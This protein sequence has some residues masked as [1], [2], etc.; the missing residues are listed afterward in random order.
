MSSNREAFQEMIDFEEQVLYQAKVTAEVEDPDT[1][2]LET[3]EISLE[4][5]CQQF[6]YEDL[7]EYEDDGRKPRAEIGNKVSS[8]GLM[9]DII[10]L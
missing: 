10:V 4:D 6:R 3:V 8:I 7:D 5:I 9:T 2:S 1:R